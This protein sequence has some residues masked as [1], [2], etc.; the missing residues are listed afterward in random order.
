MNKYVG[1]LAACAAFAA[2]QPVAAQ[3]LEV[4]GAT[5]VQRRVLEP[6]AEPLKAATGIQLKILG[7]G[8]GKGMLALF[9]GKVP[10][11]AAG[12]S[13]E[14]AV[15][16]AKA[17]AAEAGRTVTVPANLVYHPVA[18][19]NIVVA[20]HAANPVKTLTR[21]QIKDLLT[22][23]TKNW[24]D[25]GG[26]NLPVK[27]YAAA[28]GQAVRNAVQKGFMEGAEYPADATDIRTAV[29]QLKV[30]AGDPA[31]IGA[32]SEPVI[33]AGPEKVHVVTGAVIPRPL[34]FVTI[35][36]PNPQAQKMIDYFRSPEGQKQI[37]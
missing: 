34:G 23:K 13:L 16:S 10:V 27:L 4:S 35:G 19:D 9:D 15:A 12:E 21:Q 37:R 29:E 20:V 31:G 5:T 24:K 8:T 7:P 14:D 22:G 11:A 6:G 18:S 3:V 2:S 17:A 30:I 32:M 1:I 26:P 33:K 36:A 28:P 25:V